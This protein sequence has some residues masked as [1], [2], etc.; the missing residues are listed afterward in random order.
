MSAVAEDETDVETSLL[1]EAT[2]GLLEIEVVD[3]ATMLDDGA[4]EELL[5]AEG[6]L[7][8]VGSSF[9]FSDVVV[10]SGVGVGVGVGVGFGVV[11]VVVS[12]TLTFAATATETAIEES[13]LP[14]LP[15][16]LPVSKTTTFAV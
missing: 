13:E 9:F 15:A 12:S 10:G 4:G 1:V 14:E 16:A 8:V 3:C 2:V 6:V 11:E 5:T 7:E